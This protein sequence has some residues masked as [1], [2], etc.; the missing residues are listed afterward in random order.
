MDYMAN[1]IRAYAATSTFE[2]YYCDFQKFIKW[3]TQKG[4]T[5]LPSNVSIEMLYDYVRWSLSRNLS[6]QTVK[7]RLSAVR[8]FYTFLGWS[9]ADNDNILR[10]MYAEAQRAYNKEGPV[11]E[12]DAL[13]NKWFEQLWRV[14][15]DRLYVDKPSDTVE[16][17]LIVVLSILFGFRPNTL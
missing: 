14:V 9:I 16:A 10:F 1:M 12:R 15:D 2:T 5:V 7:G 8:K 6:I 11:Q 3:V 13:P 4:N 17:L